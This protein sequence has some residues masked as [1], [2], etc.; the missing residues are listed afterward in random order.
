MY[1]EINMEL[2]GS[3]ALHKQCI[4]LCASELISLPLL[5]IKISILSVQQIFLYPR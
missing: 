2:S 5:T 3:V 1:E 4:F